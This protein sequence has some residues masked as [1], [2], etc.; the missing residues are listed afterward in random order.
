LRSMIPSIRLCHTPN[1]MPISRAAVQ[2]RCHRRHT[3]ALKMPP[4]LRPRSG[5]GWMGVFG[6]SRWLGKVGSAQRA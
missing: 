1:G 5:V 6:G 3:P 4:I 2:D